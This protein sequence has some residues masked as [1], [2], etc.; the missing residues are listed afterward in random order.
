MKTKEKVMKYKSK[1]GSIELM[2]HPNSMGTLDSCLFV[3]GK[4]AGFDTV[5][6]KDV[7]AHLKKTFC[8]IEYYKVEEGSHA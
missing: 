7:E 4:G 2:L 8:S 1:L 5:A 6:K 3:G